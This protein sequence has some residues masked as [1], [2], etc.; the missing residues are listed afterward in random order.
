MIDVEKLLKQARDFAVAEY[1]RR[2]YLFWKHLIG[3][4]EIRV[5]HPNNA[6][7]EVELLPVW[8]DVSPGGAIRVVVSVLE[9]RP[10]RF[11]VSVPTTSFLV[12]E[13]GSIKDWSAAE[14]RG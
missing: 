2:G 8:D 9:L 11:R 5:R 10:E 12:F 7:V 4:D 14:T 3:R 6:D 1:G 13:D